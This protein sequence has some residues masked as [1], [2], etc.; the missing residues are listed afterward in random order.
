M[1]PI[2]A[3]F[4]GLAV[5]AV[6]WAIHA[7]IRADNAA[8]DRARAEDLGYRRGYDK[9]WRDYGKTLKNHT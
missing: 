4:T 3:F 9:G 1:N 8:Q 5:M 2:L 7:A 6:A